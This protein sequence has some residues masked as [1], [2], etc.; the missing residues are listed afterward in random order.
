MRKLKLAIEQLEVESFGTI[1]DGED[2]RGTV[3][4][5]DASATACAAGCQPAFTYDA[6]PDEG[7]VV[8][9]YTSFV[10]RED[11]LCQSVEIC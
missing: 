10:W 7:C 8:R 9:E 2:G 11:G 4:G 5:L 3:R 1:A 6:D